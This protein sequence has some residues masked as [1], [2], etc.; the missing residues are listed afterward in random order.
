M[1]NI[2]Q[3]ERKKKMFRREE[4]PEQF[5]AKKLFEQSDKRYN[6]EYQR[7]LERNWRQWKGKQGMRRRT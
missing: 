1:K 5:M 4:L 2:R 6:K 3:Q 7:K